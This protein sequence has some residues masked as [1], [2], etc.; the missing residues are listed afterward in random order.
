MGCRWRSR[1]DR[2]KMEERMI[3]KKDGLKMEEQKRKVLKTDEEEV[4]QD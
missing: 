3:M 2:L 1:R 4:G